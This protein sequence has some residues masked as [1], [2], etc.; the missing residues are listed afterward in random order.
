VRRL[1]AVSVGGRIA[2]SMLPLGVVLFARESTGSIAVAGA[3]SG[4]WGLTSALHP[5]RGRLVDRYGPAALALLSIAFAYALAVLIVVGLA[6]GTPAA[7]IV[8]AAA[9]G[10]FAPPIGPTTRAAWAARFGDG[11]E[12]Q[13]AYAADSTLE[14]VAL[15]AGPL[16]V[17]GL[18]AVASAAAA[19]GVAAVGIL[20][21]GVATATSPLARGTALPRRAEVGG[22]GSGRPRARLV[23]AICSLL[24]AG[25]ALGA[26]EVSVPAFTE[27]HGSEAASGPLIALLSVGSV[28]G[29]LWY[30]ARRFRSAVEAR[31]LMLTVALVL[32]LLPL[33]AASSIIALAPLMILPGLALGPLFVTFY[34]LLSELLKGN[35]GA[36]VFGWAVTANN[37]GAAAGAAG[38]GLVVA[39]ADP[40]A[41]FGL[42][43][44]GGALAALA[45][46]L[47]FVP[48]S[49]RTRPAR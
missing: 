7:V 43:C 23:L 28:A 49:A 30:G 21:G 33:L 34:V 2:F 27:A 10:L 25:V 45:A 15:V 39:A 16:L 42:A 46:A 44:A 36:R 41:G 48:G 32:A 26:L 17:G 20:V 1:L 29:G 18:V 6:V 5:V 11:D 38:A 8:V 14:E 47:A 4:A 3:A 19:I 12:L 40:T 24:G 35:A 37:G 22:E 9:M 31:Y 13:R